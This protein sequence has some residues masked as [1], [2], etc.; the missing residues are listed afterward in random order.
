MF[1]PL[2]ALRGLIPRIIAHGLASRNRN[3]HG[4]SPRF[5][6]ASQLPAVDSD[7]PPCH[8]S[9]RHGKEMCPCRLSLEGP[10]LSKHTY[11]CK[12]MYLFTQIKQIAINIYVYYTHTHTHTHSHTHTHTN[13][14]T[15]KHAHTHTPTTTTT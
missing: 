13:T 5:A 9:S 2:A 10:G 11:L 4:T 14:H 1:P 12:L 3:L 7:Q 15:H 8:G 6:Y